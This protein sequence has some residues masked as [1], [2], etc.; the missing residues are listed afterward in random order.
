MTSFRKKA[1]F[2]ALVLAALL[3]AKIITLPDSR[4]KNIMTGD[5]IQAKDI[6][7]FLVTPLEKRTAEERS[8][9]ISRQEMSELL[10]PEM[11]D[12]LNKNPTYAEEYFEVIAARSTSGSS[13]EA[14][15]LNELKER[16]LDSY[17]DSGR[18]SS[19]E[20]DNMM[21]ELGFALRQIQ[22]RQEEG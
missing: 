6:Q 17:I 7:E 1:I 21:H 11:I 8:R 10:V 3:L 2:S 15:I 19:F 20:R 12:F 13:S 18:P 22:R 4:G 9:L 5:R 16:I 14:S